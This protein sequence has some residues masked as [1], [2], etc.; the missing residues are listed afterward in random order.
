[1]KIALVN[2][3]H[4]GV[5]GDSQ[6]FLD[7]Q[8]KFFREIFFPYLDEN[9]IK[10]VMDL[11][12]T[13]DRRKYV[14][15]VTLKRAKEFFFSQMASRDIE[16]HAVVGNHSV[17]FTNTNEVNSMDLLL[18]E[19]KNFHIYEKEPIEL[20]FGSTRFMMVP[21]MTKD[22]R[23]ICIDTIDKSSAQILLGHFE[24]EGFEMM[25]GT[26]CD[27]GMKKDVFSKFEAVYSGHFHHPSEYGN[28]KYLGAQYEMTWSDYAGRRGFHVFDTETRDITFVENPNRIFHKIEYDDADMTIDEI[29]SLDT[30]VL[31]N[32][33][34]K[35]IVKNR[36]NSY[37]YDMFLNRIADSG[38]VDVKSVDDS[39]N[40]ESSGVDEIL[41]ETQDTKDIL[42]SYIDSIETSVEKK[43][44]KK[45]ID[46][47]Y[48]EAMNL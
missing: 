16:Y 15:Y 47:L 48:L 13:F 27:H 21:W 25:K 43:K 39:L 4:F 3:N 45:V 12:D 9:G 5:R 32:T 41:D 19:Y 40:L 37:L 1:M 17:Y 34:V 14:N 28:I 11:G 6:V 20:T 22:N 8:E 26:V 31:K 29:A 18:R 44:I 33:Y 36:T 35:V 24:I 23:D 7:H 42:H 10:I 46:E 2:D 30:S 38:A